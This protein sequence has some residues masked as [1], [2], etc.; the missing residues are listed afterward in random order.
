MGIAT[1]RFWLFSLLVSSGSILV[2]AHGLAGLG[3]H[4]TAIFLIASIAGLAFLGGRSEFDLGYADVLFVGLIATMLVSFAR[5][6]IVTDA[7]EVSLLVLTL[8]AFPAVRMAPRYRAVTFMR[9]TGAIVIVGA[10]VT[11]IAL[12]QQWNSAGK[13]FV[14]GRFDAAPAQFLNSLSF[15]VLALACSPLS[16]RRMPMAAV[17][18]GLACAICAAAQVR[19]SFLALVAALLVVR[20]IGEPAQRKAIVMLL[21]SVILGC[22]IGLSVRPLVSG[23][24][25]FQIAALFRLQITTALDCSWVD[26]NNSL[27]IRRALLQN[28][29]VAIPHAGLSGFGLDGFMKLSCIAETE[30]HNSFLQAFVEFGWLGGAL[31]V[32]LVISSV[33]L[34]MPIA[35]F[36]HEVR[37]VLSSLVFVALQSMVYGRLSRDILLFLFLGYAAGLHRRLRKTAELDEGELYHLRPL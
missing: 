1:V 9:M 12:T 8:A 23:A 34:L 14:F 2:L 30:V 24:S 6:G 18:I 32:L 33:L 27:S 21:A 3:S 11:A 7:R 31:L 25:L 19:Y 15:L 26:M 10:L 22:A 5:N 37:F 13:P 36:D 28:A 29:L 20:A 4:F 35:R 17:A 16:G